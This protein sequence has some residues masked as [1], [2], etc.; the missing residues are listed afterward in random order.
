MRS[1]TNSVQIILASILSLL[2][3]LMLVLLGYKFL[4][5][6]QVADEPNEPVTQN[7]DSDTENPVTEDLVNEDEPVVVNE[8]KRAKILANG[9]LLIHPSLFA[10]AYDV[11]S[12][13]FDFNHQYDDVRA[14]L[15]SGDLTIANYEGSISTEYELNGYPI[16]NAPPEMVDAVKNA[17]YD[18]VSLANNH[19]LD[20]HG[21]GALS[22]KAFFND[23]GID[24]LGVITQ[25]SDRILVR[26]VNGIKVAMLA[27]TYGYNGMEQTV[28]DE[29]YYSTLTPIIEEDIK[30]DIEAA[31]EISD[32]II[33]FPHM[34]VEYMM[35]PTQEQVDLYHNMIEWGADIVFGN[36]PHVVQ[37]SETV[38]RDG[39]NKLIVYSMGNFI[40]NQRLETVDDIWTERGVVLEVNIVKEGDQ[41]VE[42]ESVL[43]H[44]TWV[45]KVI[46]EPE[47]YLFGARLANFRVVFAQ[48]YL[49]DD[50]GMDAYSLERIRATYYEVIDHLNIT[51]FE[52]GQ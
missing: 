36:H 27:Y 39:L 51:G 4:S 24:T 35:E 26:D 43:A 23:A 48:D 19:I 45:E 16:F 32:V 14:F 33:V 38:Q 25:E 20:S 49:E 22:T 40:S 2:L 18:V 5:N 46:I 9:D 8:A 21:E 44:P 6:N 52:G 12:D 31:K 15:Q 47:Q 37:P 10:D 34:G 11:E 29:F 28:T 42:I 41:P 30:A 3:V 7:P 13:T 17:G 50:L 1:R